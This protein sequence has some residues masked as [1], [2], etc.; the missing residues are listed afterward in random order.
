MKLLAPCL[1]LLFAAAAAAQVQVKDPWIRAT[2]AQ[3]AV[4]GAFMRIE[5][6]AKGRLVEVK[7]P[8][9]G[10]VELHE[11]RIEQG[12]AKM[13]HVKSIALPADLKPGGYHIMLMD[14]K[15]ELKAGDS[16]PLELVVDAADGTRHLVMIQAP[17]R[18]IH[19][20][21]HHGKGH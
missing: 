19:G 16:V 21:G 7:T 12:V 5:G 1:L 9:A 2:V 6:P 3:Q 20:A 4:T 10:R 15:R 8:V 18:P 14:L 11:T 13:N 17:V